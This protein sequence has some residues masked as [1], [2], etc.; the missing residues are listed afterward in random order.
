MC[1]VSTKGLE[2]GLLAS[3]VQT[4]TAVVAW[5]SRP[6]AIGTESLDQLDLEM[7]RI[8][9]DS[10]SHSHQG[11]TDLG[12]GDWMEWL[13]SSLFWIVGYSRRNQ[14]CLRRLD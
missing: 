9:T 5:I 11:L 14:G 3:F 8:E 7:E 12:D 2:L 6:S 1:F 10:P 4:H 13:D